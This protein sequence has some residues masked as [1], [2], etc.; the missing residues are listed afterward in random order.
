MCPDGSF[1]LESLDRLAQ[2]P[3]GLSATR[4]G[5]R[6]RTEKAYFFLRLTAFLGAFAAFLAVFFLA[7]FLTAFLTAAFFTVF[8]LATV[9]PPLNKDLRRTPSRGFQLPKA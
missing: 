2:R 7:V 8:F 6:D 1:S 4:Y 9:R 5:S 3:G